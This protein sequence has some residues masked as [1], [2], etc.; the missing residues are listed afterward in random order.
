M[1]S[2]NNPQIRKQ[3]GLDL[4]VLKGKNIAA[5]FKNE[6]TKPIELHPDDS[7][8]RNA[9]VISFRDYAQGLKDVNTALRDAEESANQKIA[10]SKR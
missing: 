1:T 8:A 2:L 7:L 10:E 9:M 6:I 3:F 5:F 4:D